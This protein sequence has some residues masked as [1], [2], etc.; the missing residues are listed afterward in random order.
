MRAVLNDS[1]AIAHYPVP[2]LIMGE[3][4]TGKEII[5]NVIHTSSRR[6]LQPFVK[7]NCSAISPSLL[8]SELFGYEGG[9]F[10]G[11]LSKGKSGLFDAANEGTLL[12]DE[13][14][15]MP[16]E[17]Q[18]KIL[19]VL[20]CGDFYRVGGIRLVHVNVRIIASTNRDLR[21]MAR[22]GTFR[23]DLFY[24]LNTICICIP[25]LRERCQ[26]IEPL[27]HHYTYI[28]NKLYGTNKA[29]SRDLIRL[30]ESYSWPGNI[31]ELENIVKRLIIT[32]TEDTLT[33][34]IFHAKYGADYVNPPTRPGERRGRATLKDLVSVYEKDIIADTLTHCKNT[35]DAAKV[36]GVSQATLLRKRG[37]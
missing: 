28:C 35:R 29:F 22:E 7:I 37:R 13:V 8:E 23:T 17:L 36:L 11:A 10:T 1:V 33:P 32:S 30:L 12:L 9:A 5:A 4:G 27:L 18:A 2:V 19:R 15:D 31:R 14:G 25:P 21:A 26:D 6:R 24:R 16:Q 20:Q 3:S 34:K